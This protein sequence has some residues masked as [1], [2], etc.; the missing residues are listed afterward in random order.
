[1][2]V[3]Q[4]TRRVLVLD[5]DLAPALCIA[6]SL[7][8]KGLSVEIAS[9]HA[10]PIAGYSRTVCARYRYPDPLEMEDGFIEWIRP[11]LTDARYDLIIPVTERTVTPLLK[12][13]ARIDDTRLAMASSKSLAAVLDK[14]KTNEIAA[15][16]NIPIPLGRLVTNTKDALAAAETLGYPV[17]IKPVSSVTGRG[18][19]NIQLSVSY[20]LDAREL[21]SRVTDALRFGQ[22]LLQERFVGEGVGIELIADKGQVLYAFQHLRMHEVPLTGGGSSLR[23]SVPIEPKLL[24]ASKRLIAALEWHGVAMVEFKRNADSGDFRLMEINGRFWG[25]LPLAVHAGADFPAMLYELMTEGQIGEWPAYRS[26]IRVRNL[27]RDIYW[28]ELVARKDA[29]DGLVSVPSWRSVLSDLALVLRAGHRFDVQSWR[30]PRPGL[31]DIGRILRSYY[32]RVSG[33]IA[34]R[35]QRKRAHKLWSDGTVRQALTGAKSILFL[36]YGNINRSAVAERHALRLLKNGPS[37]IS[38]GFHQEEGRPADPIM[39]EVAATRGV[40]MLYWSSRRLT[41]DMIAASSAIFVMELQHQKRLIEEFPESRGKVFLLGMG[42]DAVEIADPYGRPR[43]EYERSLS[44]VMRG[45]DEIASLIA[46]RH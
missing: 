4:P 12:N 14:A 45:V 22:V 2:T 24:D 43:A 41:S 29:P 11:L 17:V 42:Q 26:G 19:G 20:A 21:E 44:Q 46:K 32:R 9:H 18:K 15:S 30:D 13:R 35:Q 36:C 3:V 1:M 6:R 39:T 27:E 28:H 40:D 33:I 37:V 25:S 10:H 16:L 23:A 7:H 31:I 8:R 5:G 38:A 34:E